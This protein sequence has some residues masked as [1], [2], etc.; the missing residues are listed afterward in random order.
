M[1]QIELTNQ[2][3]Q[4][5]WYHKIKVADQ[6]YTQSVVPHF[7]HMWDFN[8]NAMKIVDFN[9][10]KVLDVGCRDGLFSFEAE[11]RGAREIIGIDNDLSVG[12]TQFL[13]PYFQSKVKM[14]QMNL[15][16]LTPE[17]F[18]AFDI[19][20][21]FG[22]LYHLRY[23]VWC[24]KKLVDCLANGAVMLI[25]SGMLLDPRYEDVEFLYCPFENSPYETSSCT[26]FN[27][28]GLDTTMR[29]LGC[30]ALDCKTL[31]PTLAGKCEP[32]ALEKI[33]GKLRR[34]KSINRSVV[35]SVNRQFLAYRKHLS[36]EWPN[37]YWDGIHTV[38]SNS[39]L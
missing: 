36:T 22:V 9:D 32:G 37:P 13:I 29:S 1:N 25:E 7:Q 2:L 33:K 17:R 26:F 16:D 4:Y 15:L 20:L 39:P 6:L 8:L 3:N 24:L 31:P 38:H 11:G 19:I 35:P 14:Y 10:K 23:P 30:E 12:A 34:S 27:Q 5:K 18:G 28:K 21:F